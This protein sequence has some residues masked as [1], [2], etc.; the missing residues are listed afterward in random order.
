MKTVVFDTECNGMFDEAICQLSAIIV[1]NGEYIGINRYFAV[2]HMNDYAMRVHGLSKMRLYD[3]SGG[4]RF[5]E[6]AVENIHPFLNADVYVGHNVSQDMHVLRKNLKR[7]GI[8]FDK[9]KTFCTMKHFNSALHLK[10]KTGQAKP[11]RLDELCAYYKIEEDAIFAFCT[12]VFGEGRY[13]AHDARYDSA[14]TLLC[15]LA[16]QKCGDLKGV[17]K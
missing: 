2:D 15:V 3:L 13:H 16:A 9:A 10:G 4:V 5:E 12:R 7:I 11:P 8:N 14:A 1:E 6:W 17:I